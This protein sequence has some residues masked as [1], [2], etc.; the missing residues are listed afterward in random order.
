MSWRFVI[1]LITFTTL[2]ISD[3]VAQRMHISTLTE[4][5]SNI[6]DTP[7]YAFGGEDKKL[8]LAV[9]PGHSAPNVLEFELRQISGAISHKVSSGKLTVS[10]GDSD[11]GIQV[12]LPEMKRASEFQLILSISGS[13]EKLLS[14][15][16]VYPRSILDPV[17]VW[18]DGNLLIVKDNS[19]QVGPA[20]D[21][22]KIKWR[23]ALPSPEEG[24]LQRKAVV[25]TTALSGDG[26]ELIRS[27]KIVGALILDLS[28]RE[29]F[30]QLMIAETKGVTLIRGDLSILSE[31][32]TNPYKQS[33]LKAMF[34][35]LLSGEEGI[36]ASILE[37][38]DEN[39]T[40]FLEGVKL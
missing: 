23:A 31:I 12:P 21:A 5:R 32:T 10:Q 20:L 37:M 24:V 22:L 13:Q 26:F 25:I 30:N 17:R 39:S 34:R 28:P 36:Q 11:F 18:A 8:T 15:L 33:L 38:E 6:A 1:L 35:T 2:Y 4:T 14:K 29:P 19:E 27:K 3:A 9:E 16:V 40:R 7:I